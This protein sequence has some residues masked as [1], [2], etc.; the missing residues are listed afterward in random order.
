MSTRGLPENKV[1]EDLVR[2]F[3]EEG[4]EEKYFLL[5]SSLDQEER[6]RM[7][8]FL[9]A[10]IDVFAWQPYD[11]PEIDST[12]M[13]HKLHIDP[14][15]KPIKQKPRRAAPEKAQAIEEE[16]QKLLKAGAIREAE[17]PDWISNPVVVR[18]QNG[19]WRVCR[20]Y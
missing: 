1:Q 9:K 13:C 3:I 2:I 15:T 18:K 4:N 20:L 14:T 6:Q 10:N 12:V 7:V 19:K 11:M 16:V 17:F 5:G 8:K